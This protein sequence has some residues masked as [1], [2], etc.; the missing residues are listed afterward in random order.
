MAPL[1][2]VIL[3][4]VILREGITKRELIAIFL[5]FSG[6]VI[7]ILGKDNAKNSE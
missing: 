7:F 1:I 3:S 5:C 6:I 2:V 4:W